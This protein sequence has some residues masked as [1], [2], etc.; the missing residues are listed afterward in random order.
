MTDKVTVYI[1]KLSYYVVSGVCLNGL[2]NGAV[3]LLNNE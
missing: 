2:F 1:H 3:L